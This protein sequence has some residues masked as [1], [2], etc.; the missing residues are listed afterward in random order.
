MSAP[1]IGL[2][3]LV[4]AMWGFS[5]VAIRLG[6]QTFPPFL[7]VALRFALAA[8]PA[9]ILPR[10]AIPWPRMIAIGATLFLGNFAFL[11]SGMAAGMAAGL[12]SLLMQVQAF[13]TLLIVALVFRQ[14]P[15]GRQLAGMGLAFCGLALV[16]ATLG[17]DVTGPGLALTLAGAF[18]WACGNVLLKGAGPADMLALVAWLSLI[19]P[20]PMLALSLA[21]E[22]PSAV[23]G[24][25]QAVTPVAVGAV[26]YLALP[27]TIIAFGLWG[28]LLRHY[29]A[30]VVAPFS[31]LVP[32]TGSL[33][34]ALVLDERFEP[35]RLLGMGLIVAGLAAIALPV[36]AWLRRL[37]R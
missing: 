30:T 17:G 12:A 27:A 29:P 10:P 1:H 21:V 9:A 4:A 31:L 25:F 16:A 32:V 37:R 28:Y 36:T 26:L 14:R 35:L 8:L 3:L 18:S 13:F 33:S 5:F 34:A 19:P 6:L 11:F 7:L 2:A 15:T 22:G 24:A 20:L 23:A